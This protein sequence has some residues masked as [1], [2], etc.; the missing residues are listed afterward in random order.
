MSVH[1]IGFIPAAPLLVPELVG[2]AVERDEDLRDAVRHVVGIT[3][4][5]Q[6]D[7]GSTLIVIAE[8]PQTRDYVGSW[9]FGSLGGRRDMQGYVE[10]TA[11]LPTA[12]GIGAWF[13][14]D[15]GARGARRYLGI[16]PELTPSQCADL[17]R[18]LS[19]DTVLL[20]VGDGSACHGDKSPGSHDPRAEAFDAGVAAALG[21]ADP[22]G[23][24]SLDPG[25]A[26][27]LLVR[28]RAPWQVAAG[29]AEAGAWRGDL[30]MDDCRYG[31]AYMVA[32]WIPMDD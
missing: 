26:E 10:P 5:I 32:A 16:A 22:R 17:G 24:L 23:L 19:G 15:I 28:G 1:F 29:A 18:D 14:D 25:E 7:T 4:D 20:V 6:R 21:S 27:H 9:D 2:D 11:V 12:L 31:V 13:L 3:A 30:V 8:A